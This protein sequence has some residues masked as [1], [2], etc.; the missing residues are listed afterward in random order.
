MHKRR[1]SQGKALL[2]AILILL[3]QAGCLQ[4][5]DS[6]PQSGQTDPTAS[7]QNGHVYERV[8]L[9]YGCTPTPTH[10]SAMA[11]HR[12][13]EMVAE[14][15]KGNVIIE[16]YDSGQLGTVNQNLDALQ[17]GALDMTS[18]RPPNL[19]DVG[20]KPMG[21]LSLPFIFE[22]QQHAFRVLDSDIGRDLLNEI[23]KSGVK[24]VGIGFHK[25]SGRQLF[26]VNPVT[27]LSDL[28]GMKI[29]VQEAGIST[30][31]GVALGFN[32][33]P[34]SANELYSA[35]KSGIVEGIDNTIAAFYNSNIFEVCKN[36]TLSTHESAP[37]VI[38]FSEIVWNTLE[39]ETHELI[40]ESWWQSDRDYY[41]ELSARLD[42]EYLEDL[43]QNKGCTIHRVTD[44]E[45]WAAAMSELYAKYSV[46]VE[47][48]VKRIAAMK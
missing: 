45:D 26:T 30:E 36:I 2:A 25:D 40:Y 35:V 33:T 32:P 22:D 31:M 8:V 9:R 18:V 37:T 48:Y 5:G 28:N 23:R 10:P 24:C 41:R 3:A 15:S 16:I 14:K 46:G 47:D 12:F 43:V 27:K 39:P 17:M 4:T 29:R 38:L 13:A 1:R 34:V 11:I 42:T 44:M 20:C 6:P 21:V 19:V 7:G